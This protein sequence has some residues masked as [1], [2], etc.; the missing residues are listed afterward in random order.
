MPGTQ[1]QGNLKQLLLGRRAGGQVTFSANYT[2]YSG[3]D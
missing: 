3:T 2:L 1:G